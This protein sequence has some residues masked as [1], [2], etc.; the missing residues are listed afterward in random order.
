[1][2]DAVPHVTV[3]DWL[4]ATGTELATVMLTVAV[5]LYDASSLQRHVNESEP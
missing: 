4:L 2:D 1:M 5:P 3:A